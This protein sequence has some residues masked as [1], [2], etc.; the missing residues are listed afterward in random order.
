MEPHQDAEL[1]RVETA[2]DWAAYHEIRRTALFAI[3]RPE[4][5][6]DPDHP[7]ERRPGRMPLIFLDRGTAI[8]TIRLDLLDAERAAFRLVAIRPERQRAGLG[9]TLVE[10]AEAWVAALG[11]RSVVLNAVRPALAFYRRHGYGEG[12]W[13]DT[14]EAHLD[15]V[16]LGKRLAAASPR[17][18]PAAR[19]PAGSVSLVPPSRE[20]LEDYAAALARGWSP[21]TSRD[22]S[23][24]RLA[25]LRADPE[26]HL[27]DI[28][29]AAGT[30][31]LDDGRQVPRL[32]FRVF[33]IL[34]D[35]VFA[36]TINLRYQPAS[37]ALPFYVSG[38]VGYSIVPW[39]QRRSIAT[40]ALA[41]LLPLAEEVGLGR[42]L[43]T[44]DLDNAGSRKVILANGGRLAGIRQDGLAGTRKL[45]YWIDR[46]EG[47]RF[48]TVSGPAAWRAGVSAP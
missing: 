47:H 27:R 43:V 38:H 22:E 34:A 16:R 48:D 7:N 10:L 28:T 29:D 8:G 15:T 3:Y 1:R 32:P 36:G 30:I 17:A 9:A 25:A 31:T 12:D 45:Q 21:S 18:V 11:R 2:E 35:V 41:Q 6:Y 42:L 33:W 37:E 40:R 26:G 23:A 46:S 20:R 4:L 5:R 44:C 24:A 19:L 13:P 14:Q 39:Q